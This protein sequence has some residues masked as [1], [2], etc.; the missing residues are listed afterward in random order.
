MTRGKDE[1]KGNVHDRKKYTPSLFFRKY[2]E[3][4]PR[5]DMPRKCL[6]LPRT[7]DLG[8]KAPSYTP[9]ALQGPRMSL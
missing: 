8:V 4:S 9:K 3:E 6:Y 7:D 5:T 2:M 1:G